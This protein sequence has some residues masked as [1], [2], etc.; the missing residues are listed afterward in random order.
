MQFWKPL[1][2]NNAQTW[3]VI[4]G[5]DI[6]EMSEN[7]LDANGVNMYAGEEQ[8]IDRSWISG[9][10]ELIDNVREVPSDICRAALLRLSPRVDNEA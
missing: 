2:T 10:M 8:D 1:D 5:P 3:L 7:A 6:Y 4:L 9:S